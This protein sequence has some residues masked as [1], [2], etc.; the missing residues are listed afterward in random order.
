MNE[1]TGFH[2]FEKL[3][4]AGYLGFAITN[5][6]IGSINGVLILLALQSPA[7]NAPA[8]AGATGRARAANVGSGHT[9]EVQGLRSLAAALEDGADRRTLTLILG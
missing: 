4:Y 3:L 5:L 7:K 2:D 1:I 8:H 9:T 6:S